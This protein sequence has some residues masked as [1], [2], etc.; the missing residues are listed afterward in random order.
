MTDDA[1]V[2]QMETE[3]Y[4]RGQTDWM[5]VMREV[6]AEEY[7]YVPEGKT[8]EVIKLAGLQQLAR[9]AGITRSYPVHQPFAAAGKDAVFICVYHLH[10][11]D[12]T[13]WASSADSNPG[14]N[15]RE[16]FKFYPASCAE[17][18]AEA[19]AIRKALGITL[20]SAEEIDF[21][22]VNSVPSASTKIDPQVV[23]TIERLVKTKGFSLADVLR[24]TLAERAE[25]IATLD[26]LSSKDGVVIMRYLNSPEAS[27]SGGGSTAQ[28]KRDARKAK[29]QQGN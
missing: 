29:L 22:G 11:S 28:Q 17:S 15:S 18:R 2:P 26:Q 4:S 23:A 24:A 25:S 13:E 9:L 14:S 7:F 21:A 12:G 5:A 3:K 6:L 20:Y 16:P 19:R 10:F 8:E 1:T 27:S